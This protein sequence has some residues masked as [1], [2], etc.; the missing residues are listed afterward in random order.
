MNRITPQQILLRRF[1][2]SQ[3]HSMEC[4]KISE[5]IILLSIEGR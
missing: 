2:F 5:W 1:F 3:I 4:R